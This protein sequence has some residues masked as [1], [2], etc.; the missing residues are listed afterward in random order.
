MISPAD[1][2]YLVGEHRT[3]PRHVG[4]LQLFRLP[5]GADVDT[6]HRRLLAYG[7]VRPTF[8]R[9]PRGAVLGV[10][11]ARWD[12]QATV[13]LRQH[14]RRWTIDAPD[15]LLDLVGKL[16][17]QP[18]PRDR[19]LW[20]YHLVDGLPDRQFAVFVKAHHS[21]SDEVRLLQAA[22]A[23]LSGDPMWASSWEPEPKPEKQSL[24]GQLRSLTGTT[25]ELLQLAGKTLTGQVQRPGPPAPRS[26]LDTSH[27]GDW[28]VVMRRWS[29]GRLHA[30][31]NRQRVSRSD[32]VLAMCAGALRRYLTD[33]EA[34]PRRSLIAAVATGVKP[35]GQRVEHIGYTLCSLETN[36]P[37][38]QTRLDSVSATLMSSLRKLKKLTPLQLRMAATVLISLPSTASAVTGVSDVAPKMFNL[39]ISNLDGPRDKVNWH[40]AAL[41]AMYPFTVPVDGQALNI[42]ALSYA[43]SVLF[44]ITACRE[45]IPDPERLLDYLEEALAEIEK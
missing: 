3:H 37:S 4:L 10:A 41:E 45:Q 27:G 26:V 33:L 42:S 30:I 9:K 44:G 23:S 35:E 22:V 31:V 40:G 8:R 14:V 36:A 16:H 29:A 11:Q 7:S 32:I 6:L 12:D 2:A 17:A 24:F 20:E 43:D 38:A 39:T 1:A 28:Q 5:D 34:L 13:D 18:L 15:G 25:P 19:P 21:V